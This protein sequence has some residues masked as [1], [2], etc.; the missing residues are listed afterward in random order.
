MASTVSLDDVWS[1]KS[2][3]Q[4]F[5]AQ[6]CLSDYNDQAQ[7]VIRA[8]CLRRGIEPPQRSETSA[9]DVAAVTSLHGWYIR[10][11]VTQ[12]LLFALLILQPEF[13]RPVLAGLLP[14]LA[15]LFLA[16]MVALPII[17]TRLLARLGDTQQ[18]GWAVLMSWPLFGLLSLFGLQAMVHRWRRLRGVES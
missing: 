13:L 8:E 15:L 2:N 9:V 6:A 1:G 18:R 17:G 10:C 16:T 3:E 12:W 5:E 7:A 14:A 11:V 4:L